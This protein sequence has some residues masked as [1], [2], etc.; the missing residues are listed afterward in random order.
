M[1]RTMVLVLWTLSA[2]LFGFEAAADHC[3]QRGAAITAQHHAVV[4]RAAAAMTDMPCHSGEAAAPA[5]DASQPSPVPDHDGKSTTPC[6]CAVMF[7][8]AAA[9]EPPVLSQQ[10][11]VFAAWP[12]EAYM[13]AASHVPGVDPRP[14]RV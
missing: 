14:P 9:V 8:H 10:M 6:C 12:T 13:H 7:V 11:A 3:A 4:E 1:I 2:S 5:D